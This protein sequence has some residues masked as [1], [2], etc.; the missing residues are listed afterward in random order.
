MTRQVHTKH[1]GHPNRKSRKSVNLVVSQWKRA[2]G[3]HVWA[4][5]DPMQY[6]RAAYSGPFKTLRLGSS[7]LLA[8][9]PKQREA[10]DA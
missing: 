3:I 1:R 6:L 9:I 5:L 10:M 4:R 2:N 8:L 7:R